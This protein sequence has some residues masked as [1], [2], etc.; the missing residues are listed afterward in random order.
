MEEKFT[1]SDLALIQNKGIS[2]QQLEKQFH[3]YAN[4]IEKIVLVKPAL[5][6]DGIIKLSSEESEKYQEV[7]DTHKAS[8]SIIKFV[9][10]SGAA[11]R[12]FKFLLEFLNDFKKGEE[13]INAYINRT[14]NKELSVFLVG[15]KKFPFYNDLLKV[16][17]ALYDG[18]DSLNPD[19]KYYILIETLLSPAGF[20]FSNKPKAILPFHVK[21]GKQVTPI[22][23]HLKEA[24]YYKSGN[25]APHVHFTISKEHQ[26]SFDT[27]AN[28]FDDFVVTFSYQHEATDT[29]AVQPDNTPFRLDDNQLFF[30]PGGHGALIENL[31]ALEADLIFV[32]NIDN[33]SQNHM[34]DIIANKKMIGGLLFEIQNKVF[35]YLKIL[36]GQKVDADIMNEIIAFASKTINVVFP[37]DFEKFKKEYKIEFLMEVLNRPIRV[38]GM[39]KNEGEP[40]GG[41]FWIKDSEGNIS[42][43]IVE[44]SQMDTTNEMQ[45]RII[46]KATHFNPVDIVCG[47]KN[48][49]GEKF[50][51]K[52]FVDENSGFIVSKSKNG[53]PLKSFELPGLWNGAMAFW[54]TIF[55]EVDLITFNPV[56]TVNDLLKPAHQ[57]EDE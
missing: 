31:N 11:T 41:P 27:I 3:Y 12:M 2:I 4:G 42:L 56:K 53:K 45:E 26:E 44:G 23:D 6:G 20:D 15:I 37:L 54:N 46:Q 49:K 1:K 43:Q 40:G 21:S 19:E 33:V 16:T 22:E 13:S 24:I 5:I 50:N 17:K 57:P 48:Y 55:V 47:V 39:V 35:E 32:K 51:L 29:I 36:E 28:Q 30:R 10:A 14:N 7:F 38:C 18:F 8:T 52:E 9:P 25:V 34:K